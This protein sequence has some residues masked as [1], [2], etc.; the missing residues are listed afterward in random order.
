MS[1]KNM[2]SCTLCAVTAH[3]YFWPVLRLL[4]AA[5]AGPQY[6]ESLALT[7]HIIYRAFGI[8]LSLQWKVLQQ[9]FSIV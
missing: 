5:A 1:I 4:I 6:P 2:A 3:F 8:W 9:S 7:S